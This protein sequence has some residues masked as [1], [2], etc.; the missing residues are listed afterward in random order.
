[1]ILKSA[2]YCCELAYNGLEA[3]NAVR[4]KQFDMIL[5]DNV[6]PVM[7]GVQATREILAFKPESII[8]GI[9]GNI[10]QRDQDEF[11]QAGARFILAKPVERTQL[12][13]TCA[14]FCSASIV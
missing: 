8:V 9:T 6:M 3:V 11:L 4:S 5:M 13:Q 14:R 2:G 10:L 12:L 1:M 7:N